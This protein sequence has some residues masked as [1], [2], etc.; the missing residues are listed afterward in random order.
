MSTNLQPLA[1]ILPLD[2]LPEV[3]SFLSSPV[4]T[5][6]HNLKVQQFQNQTYSSFNR[7]GFLLIIRSEQKLGFD[8]PGTNL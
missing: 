2:S 7:A 5:A 6:L 1:Q 4:S 8:I 3:F